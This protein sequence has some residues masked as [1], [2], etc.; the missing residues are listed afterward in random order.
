MDGANPVQLMKYITLPNLLPAI[1]TS[2]I[3]NLIGGLKLFGIIQA[4]SGGGPGYT[5][6]SL[7]T[8]IN[9]IYFSYQD[10]G[11]ASTIGIFTFLF[12]MSISIVLQI[13]LNRKAGKNA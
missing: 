2:T 8:L 1:T 9:T 4:M 13:Y 10:A 11:Y 7:S 6:H 12:I 5:S 3:L